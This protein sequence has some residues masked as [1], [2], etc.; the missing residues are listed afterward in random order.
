MNYGTVAG[1]SGCKLDSSGS[2]QNLVARYS[3]IG[4]EA[5]HSMKD[6]ELLDQ[7]NDCYQLKKDS[8]PL[9]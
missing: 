1:V 8:A 6:T 5:S 7:M 2:E 3:G 4:K 9:S